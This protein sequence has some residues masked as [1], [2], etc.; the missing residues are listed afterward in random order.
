[1][2]ALTIPIIDLVLILACPVSYMFESLFGFCIL[3]A[4]SAQFYV[5]NNGYYID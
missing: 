3:A 4:S 2:H 5:E 1:M